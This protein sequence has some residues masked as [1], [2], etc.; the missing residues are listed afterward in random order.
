MGAIMLDCFVEL[1]FEH[2]ALG[3]AILLEANIKCLQLVYFVLDLLQEL[4]TR[5]LELFVQGDAL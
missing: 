2:L 5:V 3:L 1:I 4:V